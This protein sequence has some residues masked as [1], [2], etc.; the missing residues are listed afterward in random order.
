MKAIPVMLTLVCMMPMHA[1]AECGSSSKGDLLISGEGLTV[2]GRVESALQS[3]SGAEPERIV[4]G[5]QFS[6]V[7]RSCD[8]ET[9]I[10][11]VN[12][13]M[14]QHGHGM[15]YKPR[16]TPIEPTQVRAEGMLFHMPGRWEILV[17]VE[18]NGR[19]ARLAAEILI[20]P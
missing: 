2:V 4:V 15:N 19:P 18:K 11:R 17:D 10:K 20:T 6:L 14:P 16:L 3:G 9:A 1:W 7:L 8:R 13:R 5:E 12:A